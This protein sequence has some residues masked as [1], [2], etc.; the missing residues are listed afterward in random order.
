MK[1]NEAAEAKAELAVSPVA[2]IDNPKA[3]STQT[4]N[5]NT[6]EAIEKPKKRGRKPGTKTA[7]KAKE[8]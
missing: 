5:A 8:E 7:P 1:K 6:E 2:L 3:A 4:S